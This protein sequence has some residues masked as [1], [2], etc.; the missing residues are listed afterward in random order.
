MPVRKLIT[1]TPRFVCNANPG[2]A[3]YLGSAH[4]SLDVAAVDRRNIELN[5]VSLERLSDR[6]SLLAGFDGFRRSVDNGGLMQGLDSY[7]RQAFEV[8]TSP[9]LAAALDL[10][11]EDPAVRKAYGLTGE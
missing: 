6:K 4:A 7:T 9:R 1:G 11:R 8:L 2:Q 3:G 10:E 5:G